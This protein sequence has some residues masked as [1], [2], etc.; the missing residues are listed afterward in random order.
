MGE[1]KEGVDPQPE[2]PSQELAETVANDDFASVANSSADK[3][4]RES[5]S[6]RKRVCS[7]VK[8]TS[9]LSLIAIKVQRNEDLCTPR[10]SFSTV[11]KKPV[12]SQAWTLHTACPASAA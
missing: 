1:K 10:S 3:Q 4:I 2:L 12:P 6:G 5:Q 7:V 8:P 9:M 11:L